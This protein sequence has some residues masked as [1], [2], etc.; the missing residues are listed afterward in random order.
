MCGWC[1]GCKGNFRCLSGLR[2]CGQLSDVTAI[3]VLHSAG[4]CLRAARASV[5]RTSSAYASIGVRWSGKDQTKHVCWSAQNLL[6]VRKFAASFVYVSP[7]VELAEQQQLYCSRVLPP[8]TTAHVPLAR[9]T[10]GATPRFHTACPCCSATG[11]TDLCARFALVSQ[12][13]A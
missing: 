4:A 13:S 7:K 10:L 8:A 11:V 5:A 6:T 9:F 3:K 1:L 12:A 2:G